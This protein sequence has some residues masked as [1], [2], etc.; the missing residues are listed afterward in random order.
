MSMKCIEIL[1]PR[2]HY[3]CPMTRELERANRLEGNLAE[4]KRTE[5]PDTGTRPSHRADS[6]ATSFLLTRSSPLYTFPTMSLI[7]PTNSQ[8]ASIKTRF[9]WRSRDGL[10]LHL[11]NLF[12]AHTNSTDS[13]KLRALILSLNSLI[14]RET[15][16]IADI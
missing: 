11:S 3:H 12:R 9:R 6:H 14:L 15:S 16:L 8:N 4:P 1:V 2:C 5:L 13:A 7:S 10:S